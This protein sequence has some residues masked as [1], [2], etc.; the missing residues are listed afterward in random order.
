MLAIPFSIPRY[1]LR[2]FDLE[3]A[4]QIYY[5]EEE[6]NFSPLEIKIAEALSKRVSYVIARKRIMDLQK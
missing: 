2:D 1:S 6:R 3:G 5:E 4:I